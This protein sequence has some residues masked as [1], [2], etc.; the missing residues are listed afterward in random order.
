MGAKG[1]PIPRPSLCRYSLLSKRKKLERSA[2]SKVSR[3]SL[4]VKP[5][6][7]P[8]FPPNALL[9]HMFMLSTSGTLVYRLST[10]IEAMKELLDKNLSPQI[11]LEKEDEL[12]MQYLLR[13]SGV[14]KGTK[15]LANFLL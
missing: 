6:K 2:S 13:E 5:A 1:S 7:F 10:S 4:T 3:K 11:S 12:V 14:S 9:T 15:Y 8:E